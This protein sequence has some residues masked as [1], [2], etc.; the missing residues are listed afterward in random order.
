MGTPKK[1]L[2]QYGGPQIYDTRRIRQKKGRTDIRC[3]VAQKSTDDD[4][5]AT[6]AATCELATARLTE[7][8]PSIA[9]M[10]CRRSIRWDSGTSEEAGCHASLS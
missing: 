10:R 4:G 1:G 8:V 7:G 9:S 5:N 6:A 3:S 2:L